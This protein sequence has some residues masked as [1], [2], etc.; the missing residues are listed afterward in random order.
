MSVGDFFDRDR[1]SNKMADI[2]IGQFTLLANISESTR[3]T[4]GVPTTVL[5]DGSFV[6]DHIILNPTTLEIRGQVADVTIRRT[7]FDELIERI[8]SDVGL[9]NF[10]IGGKTASQIQKGVSF[11]ND[12]GD[13]LDGIDRLLNDGAQILDVFGLNTKN[14][15]E[16]TNQKLFISAMEAAH[17]GKQLLSISMP[18]RTYKNMRLTSVVTTQDNTSGAL[19]YAITAVQIRFAKTIT[20]IEQA[21]NPTSN[22]GGQTENKNTVGTQTGNEV[23]PAKKQ[24]ILGGL[25]KVLSVTAEAL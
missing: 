21:K 15:S 12:I 25:G 10:Y 22:V 17:F 9:I 20:Q 7:E 24:S 23:S 13:R 3:F 14:S 18:F 19:S 5:E 6:Q 8:Q 1:V 16:K 4:S 11:V 2:G